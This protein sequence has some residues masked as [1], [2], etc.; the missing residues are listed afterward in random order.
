M[1]YSLGVDCGHLFLKMVVLDSANRVCAQLYLNHQGD[2]T[3]KFKEALAGILRNYP[4]ER[5]GITGGL[6]SSVNGFLSEYTVDQVRAQMSWVKEKFGA[7]NNIFD[8]GGASVSLIELDEQGGFKNFISNSLCAAGTGSFLDEQATRLEINYQDLCEFKEITAPPPI[9][10]RCSVF[11][12]SDL[13]H[14]QQ[15]GYNR[16]ELWAGLCRGLCRTI[17]RTLLKGRSLEGATVALGGMTQNPEVLRWLKSMVKAQILTS[18]DAHLAG[19]LGS[20]MLAQPVEPGKLDFKEINFSVGFAKQERRPKLELKRSSYPDFK[21]QE[22]YLDQLGNEVR[23]SFLPEANQIKGFLGI[24][25]GST[26]TKLALIDEP[27]RVVV[28]IYRKTL[29]EP[30]SATQKLFQALNSLFLRHNKKLEIL[31]CATTGS[32]RKLVGAVVGADLVVNE[33]TCH[34]RGAKHWQDGVE[35]IFEIG[36]QDSKY[37]YLEDGKLRQANLNYACAAGTGSFVEE[38]ARKLGFPVSEVG[39]AVLGTEP[40]YTSDRCTVFMEQDAE[41][42]LTQ[43]FSRAEVMSAVLYSVAQ[44]YLSKVVGNRPRSRDKIFFQGATARNPGLV[45]AF[46]NILNQEIVVSPYC[47]ILGALGA[48]LLAQEKY[49][50]T[51]APT[52]FR[53]MDLAEREINLRKEN[54]TLCEN[55]CLITYAEIEGAEQAPSFGYL[56]GRD[57]ESNKKRHLK[58]YELFAQRAR[59]FK[60]AGEVKTAE[61]QKARIGV[62]SALLNW[63]LLPLWRRFFNELGFEV[64]TTP[65]TTSEIKQKGSEIS[66]GEFCFP[67]VSA[68]GHFACLV[69]ESLDFVF[70]PYY[71]SALPNPHTTNSFYCPYMQALPSVLCSAIR[72]NRMDDSRVFSPLVDF[73]WPEEAQ[74][75]ELYSK[76]KTPLGV[77]K[78]QVKDAWRAG[79]K[80]LREF[81]QENERIGRQ[82]LEAL[83]KEDRIGIVI[84]GRPYN[85]FDPGLNLELAEKIAE[86]GFYVIPIDYLPY[87]PELLGEEFRNIYWFYGQKVLCALKQIR[88]NPR[89]Y[90]IY[91][92]NFNCGPDSFLI[93]Y[94]EQVMGEKPILVLEFDEHGADA[95]YLTRVEAFLDLVQNLQ[96]FTSAPSIYLPKTETEELKKR[97]L[98]VPPMHPVA[99]RLGASVLRS[100]GWNAEVLPQETEESLE[101]GRSVSR[102]SECLPTASTIGALLKTLK[103]R[104]EDP[105]KCAFFMATAC[106]PCRFGQYTLLHRLILNRK[107][108]QDLLILAPSAVNSYQ[109]LDEPIRRKL[110]EIFVLGDIIFKIGCKLRPYELN[111]GETNQVIES[112]LKQLE[113]TIEKR[114]NLEK[115]FIKVME[116]FKNI[117]I[118]KTNKPLVAVVG[119]IYVRANLFDNDRIIEWIEKFGGEAWLAPLSEWFFYT[120][121]LQRYRSKQEFINFW[122]KGQSILKNRFMNGIE[123]KYSRI[124]HPILF[125]REEPLID[126]IVSAGEKYIP[127]N[128]EGEAILTI[129]RA[130]KFIDQGAKLVVNCAPFGCMP[131]TISNAIF[132]ELSQSYQLPFISIFYDGKPGLNQRLRT[133]IENLEPN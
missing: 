96:K 68:H 90:P 66:A 130:I 45:A 121:Y 103:E 27:G 20:A 67:V 82:A 93:Q 37:I 117:P 123:K 116:R 111:P 36:G 104:D 120:A 95:G 128:F 97:K 80:T 110:W 47:H 14:Y 84:I 1:G 125:D 65:T 17:L 13:I 33:I 56:C 10:A 58:E 87:K 91:F 59:R 64:I 30:I 35:T 106:G 108:Y 79:L 115:E 62:P 76:L 32:G 86:L 85:V 40:P 51:K 9:A 38:L 74:I 4:V 12:K 69:D 46:E 39:K 23:L 112:S 18:K 105:K 44:N 118:K 5:L 81:E 126:D 41:R 94:A 61:P 25:I 75:R 124:A 71:I 113:E 43:G 63:S 50:A 92:S 72:I 7:V 78:A 54:C 11:A 70:L 57:P 127:I 98:Y 26:S 3:G 52:R 83:E 53:G 29:G 89:L 131:G 107:G 16:E 28:D 6:V 129:G 22:E 119:E 102:G 132:Q 19:A 2:A 34:Y 60:R 88:E 24:D 100:F 55:Q 15:E 109:G 31:G 48:G 77:S 101:L 114:G 8:L 133:L 21:V 73:R 42:L 99:P 122:A 49:Q